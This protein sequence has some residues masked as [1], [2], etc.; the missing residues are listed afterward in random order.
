MIGLLNAALLLLVGCGEDATTE[1]AKVD[2]QSVKEQ[3]LGSKLTA[4]ERDLL[5]RAKG[6]EWETMGVH[7]IEAYL[8]P[9]K[10]STSAIFLWDPATGADQ[11]VEVQKAVLG[12]DTIGVR[13]AIAVIAGGNARNELVAL[14][15]SQS[16]LPAFR[17]PRTGDYTFISGGLPRDNSLIVSQAGGEGATPFSHKTP[18][19]AL[20]PLLTAQAP[21]N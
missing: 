19:R 6:R 2:P 10:D 3:A 18:I 5:A 11:L 15:E 13:V 4:E 7:D 17:I 9:Q 21:K 1:A 14:R 8:T 16:V 20:Q 12:M